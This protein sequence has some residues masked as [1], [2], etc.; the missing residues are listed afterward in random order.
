MI[1]ITLFG[2]GR[3]GRMH[4]RTLHRHDAYDLR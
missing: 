1:G 3:I 4:G 2:A